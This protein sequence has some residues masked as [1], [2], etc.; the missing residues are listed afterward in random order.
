[1]LGQ[2]VRRFRPDDRLAPT[3]LNNHILAADD[4]SMPTWAAFIFD[5]DLEDDG[6]V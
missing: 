2:L 4:Q 1:M 3:S 6:L 5:R